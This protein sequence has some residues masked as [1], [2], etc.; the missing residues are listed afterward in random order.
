MRGPCVRINKYFDHRRHAEQRERRKTRAEAQHKQDRKKMF[1]VGRDMSRDLGRN[2]RNLVLLAKQRVSARGDRQDAGNL[3]AARHE[4]DRRD[5]KSRHQREKRM[6]DDSRSQIGNSI[7]ALAQAADQ[8]LGLQGGCVQ[9]FH[10]HFVLHQVSEQVALSA[11][12]APAD[13]S[14]ESIGP[15]SVPGY[16]SRAQVTAC[17][18]DTPRAQASR[19]TQAPASS[20][21]HW[22]TPSTRTS[23]APS[24]VQASSSGMGACTRLTR[25][26]V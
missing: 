3:R 9:P 5:G 21:C 7:P 4:E 20:A 6:T 26:I 11:E 22:T 2:H 18:S 19:S 10:F 16:T 13:S 23:N 14:P 24:P 12:N 8:R 15:T 1:R 17:S 25:Q